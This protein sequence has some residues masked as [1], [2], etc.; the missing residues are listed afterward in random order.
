MDIY[1]CSQYRI[2]SGY[3]C[4]TK[5]CRE[6]KSGHKNLIARLKKVLVSDKFPENY[7]NITIHDAFDIPPNELYKC[8]G[9]GKESIEM[10][11]NHFMDVGLDWFHYHKYEPV[12]NKV[13]RRR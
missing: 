5:V 12:R 11:K 2:D 4:F 3:F 6:E 7:L 13:G 10:L 1:H 8:W 9:I